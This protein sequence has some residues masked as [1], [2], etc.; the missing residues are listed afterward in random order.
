MCAEGK[1]VL[2]QTSPVQILSLSSKV[3]QYIQTEVSSRRSSL[4][5][6]LSLSRLCSAPE[7]A[8]AVRPDVEFALGGG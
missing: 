1:K 2:G 4:P 7:E 5:R 6:S 3:F 8:S